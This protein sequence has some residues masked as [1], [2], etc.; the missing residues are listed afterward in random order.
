[1]AMRIIT[2]N[3]IRKIH[4]YTAFVLLLFVLMYFVTGFILTHESWF[5]HTEP[6]VVSQQYPVHLPEK[7]SMNEQSVYLQNRF[8][9]RAKKEEAKT[10]K[11]GSIT[12]RYFK[13][14]HLYTVTIDSSR[15]S[16][17]LSETKLPAHRTMIGFH[18][19]HGYG[20]GWLYN[21]YI[22]MMDLASIATILFACTGIYLWYKLIKR[23]TWGLIILSACIGY[24]AIVIYLFM[25]G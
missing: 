16:A 3:L 11:D 6:K 17:T 23:K 14:G 18:R 12:F 21:I 8:N 22:F 9:I 2:Y 10:K 20:G 24:T 5:K 7:L 1:M 4:L 13:P 25:H 19:M 15:R